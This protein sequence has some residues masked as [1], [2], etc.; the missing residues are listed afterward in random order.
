M[1]GSASRPG[2]RHGTCLMLWTTL[3]DGTPLA[4]GKTWTGY[5]DREED[6]MNAALGTKVNE[7]TIQT[8]AKKRRNTS[9]VSAAPLARFAI[10]ALFQVRNSTSRGCFPIC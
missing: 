8:E 2:T 5:R 6:K 9:F 10:L 4:D 1:P 3:S 7:Y